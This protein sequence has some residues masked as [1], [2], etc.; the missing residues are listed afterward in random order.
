MVISRMSP[1]EAYFLWDV[2]LPGYLAAFSYVGRNHNLKDLQKITDTHRP[3]GGRRVLG[4]G[5]LQEPRTVRVRNFEH[6]L[7][8]PPRGA[9][10]HRH[11]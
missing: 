4:I 5:Q 11:F 7:Y 10:P 9:R 3:W 1:N 6:P 8:L 2:R